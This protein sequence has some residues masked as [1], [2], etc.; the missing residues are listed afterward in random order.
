[1][2]TLTSSEKPRAD[3]STYFSPTRSKVDIHTNGGNDGIE[4]KIGRG[5]FFWYGKDDG[6]VK[7]LKL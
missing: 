1:M 4:I 2:F 6:D 7:I 5:M 3:F